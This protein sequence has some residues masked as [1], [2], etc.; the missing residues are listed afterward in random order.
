LNPDGTTE[1]VTF[2]LTNVPPDEDVMEEHIDNIVNLIVDG[3]TGD[4]WMQRVFRVDE[5]ELMQ[6]YGASP[7]FHLDFTRPEPITEAN[8]LSLPNVPTSAGSGEQREGY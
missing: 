8:I 5:V 2:V 4:S 6:E 7:M 1:W 3:R